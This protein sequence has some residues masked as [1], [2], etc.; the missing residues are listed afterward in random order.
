MCDLKPIIKALPAIGVLALTHLT[1]CAANL[2]E[3][4]LFEQQ[5]AAVERKEMI[6]E[7]IIACE[8]NGNVVVYTGPSTHKLRDPIKRIPKYADRS[9]YQCTRSGEVERMQA[10]MGIR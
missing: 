5:Y 9:D 2:T 4:E 7:F 1:G 6:R 10:E 8:A 3:D